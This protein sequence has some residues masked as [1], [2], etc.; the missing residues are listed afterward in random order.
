MSPVSGR[1]T[2][3]IVIGITGAHGIPGGIAA[4]NRSVIDALQEIAG[5]RRLPLHV[6][7]YLEDEAARPPRLEPRATFA[8][9]R[10]SRLR[11]LRILLPL[12]GRRTLALF[13]HV[14]LAL[15]ALPWTR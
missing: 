3:R 15:P 9:A 7:S 13:D 4:S 14:G 11:F 12:L 1:V 5:D 10:G 8:G 6:V 2:S